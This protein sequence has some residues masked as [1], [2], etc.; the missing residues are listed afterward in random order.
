MRR[1]VK[2]QGVLGDEGEEQSSVGLNSLFD[3]SHH[4]K[5]GD[6]EAS[7][8]S[9]S[10]VD[11]EEEASTAWTL[12]SIGHSRRLYSRSKER[13]ALRQAYRRIWES[14]RGSKPT[15]Q[16]ALISGAAG[17]GKTALAMSIRQLVL[18][19]GGFFVAGKFDQLQS[20]ELYSAFVSA[21][22]ELVENVVRRGPEAV[23]SMRR[24]I[25]SAVH[26]EQRILTDMI[27]ALEQILGPQKKDIAKEFR[28]SS[29]EVSCFKF[30]FRMFVRAISSPE[31][32]IVFLLD[33]LH[34]ADESS[35]DLLQSLVTD[36]AND[37][38][39]F[40]GT[41]RIDKPSDNNIREFLR[42]KTS[43]QIT[44]IPLDNLPSRSV[45]E[46]V[47]EIFSVVHASQ[48][49][50]LTDIIFRQ[51]A[52]NVFYIRE[53]LRYLQEE[54]LLTFDEMGMEWVWDERKIQMKIDFRRVVELM[55]VR[56][57][58]LPKATREVLE[59]AAC[60]GSKLDEKLLNRISPRPVFAQLQKAACRG[61]LHY[62]EV[63]DTY[64]FAHD[65][66]Q[67]A[68]YKLISHQEREAFHLTIGR[69]LWKSFD[70]I[71][72]LENHIFIILGQ[73][74]GGADLISYQEERNDVAAL[75]LRAGELAI[76]SSSF[77]TASEYLLLGVSML[78]DSC[79]QDEYEL[80]LELYNAA[81]EVEYSIA[82]FDNVE[83]LATEIFQNT[84]WF[85]DTLRAH[86]IHV[87]SLGSRGHMLKAIERGLDVLDSLGEQFPV[88][89]SANSIAVAVKR[90]KGMLRGKSNDALLRMP[91]MDNPEKIAAMQM[92][93]IMFLYAYIAV[94][95][96]APLIAV[97][98][99]KLTIEYGLCDVSSVGFVTFAML[100]SGSGNDVD[101]GFRCGE[102]AMKIYNKF[103]NKAWLGRLSAWFYGSVC[104]WKKPVRMVFEPLKNAHRVALET[105]DIDFAMLNANIYCWESFDISS[106]I[107]LEKIIMGFS[108][109]MKAYGH[110]SVL[111][112]I[113]PLWQMVHNFMGRAHVDPKTLTGEIMEQEYTIQY[114]RENNK[115]LLIWLHFYRLLLAYMF[116]DY[117]SAEIHATVCRVAESNPFGSSDR[118]LLVF[119]DG[120]VTLAQGKKSR[121]RMQQAKRCIK[122]FKKWAKQ[123]PE[124]FLGKLY[125]LEAE[126]AAATGDHKRAHSKYTS[127]IS[128]SRE[129]G[130][131]MQHA[132]AN[133]R[134]GL[135][136]LEKGDED[137]A[138]TYLR[139]ALAVYNKWGGITKCEY[140]MET[141]PF[142]LPAGKP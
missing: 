57:S 20:S 128:L 96:L 49:K 101:E 41:Y 74:R 37:G 91:L 62:D 70:D 76:C 77:Q 5:V 1:R 38:I 67:E 135:Y 82:N 43:L 110:E 22:S 80:S 137:T 83:K 24:A 130:Y 94:P 29:D 9:N 78:G 123:S 68:A 53:F 87:Y 45:D 27:P 75:C 118:V 55:T 122:T 142:L 66:I 115:T 127:A 97:R 28:Q 2:F 61:F 89:K 120:L 132:L 10:K 119:Y 129:G 111:M 112:M 71:E 40:V 21:F 7:V 16:L 104:I 6:Q 125:F 64:R 19:D 103:H 13:N 72:D 105:G 63:K 17:I 114:A 116:G 48:I 11:E 139:E 58:K 79:W 60:L 3:R 14:E 109:R 124:N 81:A 26:T 86:S 46:M 36:D 30:V 131:I 12:S 51:T 50:P 90:I 23:K 121:A 33:D 52:G 107:K 25:Q 18:D 42:N 31:F 98:M 47:A 4:S 8:F 136:F 95:T 73:I 141:Y 100:L 35:L 133:E 56:I 92:M 88:K 69:E 117:E 126:H 32:P 59:V 39:L 84:R 102:L 54:G 108:N 65:I 44:D 15:V 99:V 85:P 140:L 106:L 113:K 93:N 134:A 34:F 138:K